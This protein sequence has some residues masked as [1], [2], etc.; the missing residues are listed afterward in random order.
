MF[1]ATV[2]QNGIDEEPRRC[3]VYCPRDRFDRVSWLLLVV[4]IFASLLSLSRGEDA[5]ISDDK[6]NDEDLAV[7]GSCPESA[8]DEYRFPKADYA[9]FVREKCRC[10][11]DVWLDARTPTKECSV[12]VQGFD[13]RI[14]SRIGDVSDHNEARHMDNGFGHF[15]GKLDT[16]NAV[17]GDVL[18]F[19]LPREALVL[20]IGANLGFF[21]IVLAKVF[22][23]VKILALEAS[24]QT[25]RFA[26][27]NVEANGVSSNVR[28]RCRALTGDGRDVHMHNLHANFSTSASIYAGRAHEN[29]QLSPTQFRP[30]D[31][32]LVR[33]LSMKEVL[34]EL[35]ALGQEGTSLKKLR[36]KEA[37]RTE[38]SH[39]ISEDTLPEAHSGQPRRPPRSDV[40]PHSSNSIP[41]IPSVEFMKFNLITATDP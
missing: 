27:W 38:A 7:S 3:C 36:R 17:Y 2:K 16:F 31:G 9:A 1:G 20:D 41:S 22:P 14:R 26:A 4:P 21:S 30:S 37:A 5:A 13:L 8:P 29:P 35:N 25:C 15:G 24:P 19:N 6:G 40:R 28:L 34:T 18:N 12:K 10:S 11:E 33:S 39:H 23:S 32:T